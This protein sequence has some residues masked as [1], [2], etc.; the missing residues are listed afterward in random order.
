VRGSKRERKEGRGSYFQ[1]TCL[2]IKKVQRNLAK[3]TSRSNKLV[4]QDHGIHDKI[5]KSMV[6]L[7][8][9]NEYIETKIN[10]TSLYS[11]KNERE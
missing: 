7:Y 11:L 6:F 10:N 3:K 4:Q 9:S 2:S 8:I 5:Q 1:I